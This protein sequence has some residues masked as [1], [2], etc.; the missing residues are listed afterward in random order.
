MQI[1]IEI[2]EPQDVVNAFLF[3]AEY[4][5][6]NGTNPH[7]VIEQ[8]RPDFGIAQDPF[9]AGVDFVPLDQ[10]EFDL[11]EAETSDYTPIENARIEGDDA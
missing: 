2:N 4:I 9:E 8:A 3:L 1:R 6:G 5:F 11:R 10:L 7:R